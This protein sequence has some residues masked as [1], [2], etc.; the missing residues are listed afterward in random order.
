MSR[1]AEARVED[2]ALAIARIRALL[3]SHTL[4]TLKGD[5]FALAAFERFLEIL[6]EASRHIPAAWKHA[7]GPRIPWREIADIG[8]VIRH[9]Y[10]GVSAEMLWA[11]H[12]NDLDA[13]AHAIDG[14]RRNHPSQE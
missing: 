3:A 13:L 14:M 8:N 9:A 5:P 4:E 11:I 6:S 7:H 10:D 1:S 12:T 2:V